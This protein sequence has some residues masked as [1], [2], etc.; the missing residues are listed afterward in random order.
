MAH[1]FRILN[2]ETG[3][4][5][6]LNALD[7]EIRG[8][9][10]APPDP[11]N[12]FRGWYDYIGLLICLGRQLG[13]PELREACEEAPGMIEVLDY[14]EEHYVSESWREYGFAR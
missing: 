7:D 9:L 3:E 12:W 5:Q 10:G 8:A 2:K 4:P 6:K 13:S 14:L 11:K 1:A